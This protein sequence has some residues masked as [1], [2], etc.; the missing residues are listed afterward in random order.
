M[1]TSVVEAIQQFGIEVE[2][3]NVGI[4]KALKML[5][6]KNWEDW[7]LDSGINVS[8]VKTPTQQLIVGWVNKAF[9]TI[10]VDID[11]HSWRHEVYSLL[12]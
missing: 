8:V 6:C 12:N 3:V 1:M 7:M 5:V 4:N 10:S 11:Q 2:P 9:D